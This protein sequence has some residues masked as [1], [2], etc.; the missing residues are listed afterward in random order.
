M[1]LNQINSKQSWKS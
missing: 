1:L